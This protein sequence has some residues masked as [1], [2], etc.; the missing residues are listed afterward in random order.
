MSRLL[1]LLAALLLTALLALSAVWLLGELFAGLGALLVASS[2]LLAGLLRFG[3][4]AGVLSAAAYIV[5]SAW[6]RPAR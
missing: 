3:L 5:L 2:R 4:I 6:R 1:L